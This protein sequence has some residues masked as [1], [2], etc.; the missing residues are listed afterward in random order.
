MENK[1]FIGKNGF[2]WWVGIIEN[3]VDPLTVGRCQV[4]I[5]GWHEDD[6]KIV[7]TKDLP[8]AQAMIPLNNSKHFSSPRVG[9]WVVGFFMDGEQGQLPVMM[10]VLPG[11][12]A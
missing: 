2:I 5:I 7:P 3:R 8:W 4:R 6:P 12:K 9:E 1:N 10:G 11:L